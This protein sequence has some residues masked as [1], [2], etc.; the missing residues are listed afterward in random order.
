MPQRQTSQ[1]DNLYTSL[2]A[3]TRIMVQQRT[4]EIKTLMR[5]SAQD[6]VEIG[7]KLIEVKA[8]LGRGLF[9]AWLRI[10]FEWSRGTAE[11]YVAVALRFQ[12]QKFSDFDVA[13]SA[14]Y[15]L[16]APS[17]PESARDEVLR[18]A[19]SGE[20]ITFGTAQEVIREHKS[21]PSAQD[22][23]TQQR[24]AET[25]CDTASVSVL[26]ARRGSDVGEPLHPSFQH[27]Q[28]VECASEPPPVAS[29]AEVVL[30][31]AY[32]PI[33]ETPDY[34]SDEWYTPA[35]YIEAARAVMGDIDLDPATCAAAQEMIRARTFLT[36]EDDGLTRPWHGRVWLNPPYSGSLSQAACDLGRRAFAACLGTAHLRSAILLALPP[37]PPAL[38]GDLQPRRAGG[39]QKM[40]QVGV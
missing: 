15:M 4:S 28:V 6:I 14:L 13:P 9:S 32:V 36:K 22:R 8:Q 7:Q 5:R 10:E 40:P 26:P 30:P 33:S 31:S 39:L 25:G 20:R 3:E 16:A 29:R 34:D 38:R 23:R 19:E 37:L 21:T 18:R 17:T 35:E 1:V 2:D 24:Q 11:N 12:N 27:G